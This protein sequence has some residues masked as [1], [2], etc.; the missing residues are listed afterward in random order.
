MLPGPGWMFG[1]LPGRS[2]PDPFGIERAQE[3]VANMVTCFLLD[4][5]PPLLRVGLF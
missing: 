3:H 4:I 1:V 2:A 5:F